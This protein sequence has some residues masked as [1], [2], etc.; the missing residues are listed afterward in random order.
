MCVSRCVKDRS[1]RRLSFQWMF[2]FLFVWNCLPYNLT[3]GKWLNLRSIHLVAFNVFCNNRKPIIK[4]SEWNKKD[5]CIFSIIHLV[6]RLSFYC[7]FLHFLVTRER[8]EW[9]WFFEKCCSFLYEIFYQYST[10]TLKRTHNFYF[11]C[12]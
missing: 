7:H 3:I 10:F 5:N 9:Y 11:A 1:G 2:L 12:K 8:C 4:Y 6:F